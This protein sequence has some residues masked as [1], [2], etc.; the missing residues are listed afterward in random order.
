MDRRGGNRGISHRNGE[1]ME[2]ADYIASSIETFN[3]GLLMAVYFEGSL[4]SARC[5]NRGR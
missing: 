2:V 1:L 4:L 5:P 3:A